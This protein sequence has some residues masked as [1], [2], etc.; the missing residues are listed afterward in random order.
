MIEQQITVDDPRVQDVADFLGETPE[1]ALQEA[2]EASVA[3]GETLDEALDAAEFNMGGGDDLS[4][5]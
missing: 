2:T 3:L 1:E 4:D 5:F